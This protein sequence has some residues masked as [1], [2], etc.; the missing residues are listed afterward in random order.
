MLRFRPRTYSPTTH[1]PRC[2]G[3]SGR[4]ARQAG[5]RCFE[6]GVTGLANRDEVKDGTVLKR[7]AGQL[8][9]G[10]ALNLKLAGKK[11]MLRLVLVVAGAMALVPPPQSATRTRHVVYSE[12]SLANI[13]DTDIPGS[14]RYDNSDSVSPLEREK[15]LTETA[16]WCLERC[17]KLGH[18]EVFED[19]HK[20]STTQVQ[21]F[22]K[23]CVISGET[24]TDECDVSMMFAPDAPWA[25]K[26]P[27]EFALN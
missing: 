10:A 1:S 18:C 8:Q 2:G 19:L 14:F 4:Q 21:D 20:M 16:Q 24:T 26:K 12:E 6:L 27:E 7:P 13:P 11:K 23:A 25:G 22:C 5:Q 15:A 3:P 17:I 9:V